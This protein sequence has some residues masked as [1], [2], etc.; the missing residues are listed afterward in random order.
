M[1][2]SRFVRPSMRFAPHV[3]V[4][5]CL[6]AAEDCSA[7]PWEEA[8][9]GLPPQSANE[10][11]KLCTQHA[12]DQILAVANDVETVLI[13]SKNK[14]ALPTAHF[15]S[16]LSGLQYTNIP[17]QFLRHGLLRIEVDQETAAISHPVV[18]APGPQLVAFDTRTRNT[19]PIEVATAPI[20]IVYDSETTDAQAAMGILGRSIEVRVRSTGELLARRTEFAW[21][22]GGV[23]SQRAICPAFDLRFQTQPSS[24]VG[25]VINPDFYPCMRRYMEEKTTIKEMSRLTPPFR[26]PNYN[27]FWQEV[28][29]RDRKALA[30]LQT[31][32]AERT[33]GPGVNQAPLIR[34]RA[35]APPR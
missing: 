9:R 22:S 35:P 20:E 31:C 16:E 30:D 25:Q 11:R 12:S 27:A 19:S 21:V 24:F 1:A 13:R 3:A 29:E 6:L 7:A 15:Y 2:F 34:Y 17:Y 32:D 26:S 33:S 5:A 8:L 4:V 14:R 23:W 10:I 28:S 18:G